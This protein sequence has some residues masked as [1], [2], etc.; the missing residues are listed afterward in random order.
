LAKGELNFDDVCYLHFHASFPILVPVAGLHV[1]ILI[2]VMV[3]VGIEAGAFLVD[4]HRLLEAR[5]GA[6]QEAEG[7]HGPAAT[8]AASPS[9]PR[10]GVRGS[11]AV[12][13]RRQVVGGEVGT[14]A[15]GPHPHG[16]PY[17]T[18]LSTQIKQREDAQEDAKALV[19]P[20]LTKANTGKIPPA[21]PLIFRRSPLPCPNT[22]RRPK[23]QESSNK[24]PQE[25][26]SPSILLWT[27]RLISDPERKRERKS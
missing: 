27:L 17:S 22:Q 1:V 5:A 3:L 14:G 24:C 15:H 6:E 12:V 18:L 26:A 20:T 4:V 25:L 13:T 16:L 7:T 2:Q 11:V 10:N 8:A 23:E 9:R 19:T 21:K